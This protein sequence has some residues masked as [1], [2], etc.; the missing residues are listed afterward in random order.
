M[1]ISIE[2]GGVQDKSSRVVVRASLLQTTSGCKPE[3]DAVRV[4][5][6][7]FILE[8]GAQSPSKRR[9]RAVV[10][11][12]SIEEK[13]AAEVETILKIS[14]NVLDPE[15]YTNGSLE[16]KATFLSTVKAQEPSLCKGLATGGPYALV[17]SN[18]TVMRVVKRGKYEA[19]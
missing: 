8:G 4:L 2:S 1:L 6:S 3:C 19:K 11:T 5:Q 7:L 10:D 15:D 14:Q 18:I 13:T 12:S 16:A 9:R 17:K